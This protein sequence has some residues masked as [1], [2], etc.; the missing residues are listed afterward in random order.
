MACSVRFALLQRRHLG[1][2]WP[3]EK[4][5]NILQTKKIDVSIIARRTLTIFQEPS[6]SVSYDLLVES[7]I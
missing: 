6:I 7:R 5:V 1:L 3:I 2:F 4:R